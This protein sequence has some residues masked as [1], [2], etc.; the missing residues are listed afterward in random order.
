MHYPLRRVIVPICCLC[1]LLG[2]RATAFPA[3]A[4]ALSSVKTQ[5]FIRQLGS[6]EFEERERASKALEAIGRRALPALR[7]AAKSRDIEVRL[8]A[9]KLVETLDAPVLAV[10]RMGG[11]AQVDHSHP[12]LP[13]VRVVL[14]ND[15]ITDADL[16]VLS[17]L[18]E[19]RDVSLGKN[20]GDTGLAHL[21]DLRKIER[22]HLARTRVTDVGLKYVSKWRSLRHLYLQET[23]VTDTGIKH[24]ASLQKLTG[25]NLY[26]TQV[27]DNGVA[28]LKSLKKLGA[29]SLGR[30][31]VTDAGLELP[32]HWRDT[33][34]VL[35]LQGTT[36]TDE[37]LRHLSTFR[38]L[39]RLDLRDTNVTDAG[40]KHLK[41]LRKLQILNL[42]GTKVTETAK[43]D[44]KR[45]VPGLIVD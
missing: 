4:P 5:H 12:D 7:V 45:A 32:P 21:R 3:A 39:R 42:L 23:Q 19:L 18:P 1:L 6:E 29:L 17:K 43:R 31:R 11:G 27:T 25:L 26:G 8:R 40:I 10:L 14:R 28:S 2:W 15:R 44:L 34:C 20:I 24:L 37:G 36:V 30:T 13:V 41:G 35:D 9:R 22:L 38:E 33:L 16:R